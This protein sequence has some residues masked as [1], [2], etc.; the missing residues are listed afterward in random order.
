VD[1]PS[2]VVVA[3]EADNGPSAGMEGGN[4]KDADHVGSE[5]EWAGVYK[6]GFPIKSPFLPP[7]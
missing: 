2:A 3:K 5:F 1:G 7:P 4:K 6:G